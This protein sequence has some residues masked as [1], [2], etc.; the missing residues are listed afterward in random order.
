MK[1]LLTIIVPSFNQKQFI[2]E[3]IESI[4]NSKNRNQIQFI[5]VDGKSNDGTIELIEQNKSLIDNIIIE[6]DKGQSDAVNKGFKL[7]LGKYIIWQ[8]SDDYFL[9]E[10]LERFIKFEKSNPGFDVYFGNTIVLEENTNNKVYHYFQPVHKYNYKN[11]GL[12]CN[13]QSAFIKRDS[14]IKYENLLDEKFNYAMDRELFLRLYNDKLRFKHMNFFVSV[15]RLQKDSKSLSHNANI[16]WSKELEILYPN[17]NKKSNRIFRLFFKKLFH[18]EKLVY[19]LIK[20]P[21]DLYKIL[22]Q[23]FIK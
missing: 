10:A 23:K 2:S 16:K 6:S 8:N 21:N 5:L 11:I 15:F 20:N 7:A 12:I 9:P 13:N 18:F 17:F 3:C 22:S 19:Y 1:Y 4:K 14:L